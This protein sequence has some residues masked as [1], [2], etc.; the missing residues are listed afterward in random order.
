[1]KRLRIPKNLR[2]DKLISRFPTDKIQ[3]FHRD[4]VYAIL[5]FLRSQM[6]HLNRHGYYP[7]CK[8][9][10]FVPLSSDVLNTVV[11]KSYKQLLE[12]MQLAGIIVIDRH[13]IIGKKCRYYRL[14]DHYLG[15]SPKWVTVTSESILRKKVDPKWHLAPTS[16]E[17]LHSW[18]E[19]SKLQ[20]DAVAATKVVE[21]LAQ[22]RIAKYRGANISD[23][24]KRAGLTKSMTLDLITEIQKPKDRYDQ[25]LFGYRL[26]T[27]L[28]R[29][30]K[31]LRG[32][33]TCEGEEIVQLDIRNSQLFFS[34]WL[35][36]SKNWA[37]SN[38]NHRELKQLF[39]NSTFTIGNS[40]SIN[41]S[42]TIMVVKSLE[43][44]YGQGLQHHPYCKDVCSGTLYE[45]VVEHL[46]KAGFFPTHWKFKQKRRK[47]KKTLLAQLFANPND[48]EH[49]AST[50]S[51]DKRP[52]IES[53]QEIY[54]EIYELFQMIKLTDYRELCRLLQRVESTAVLG[55]VCKAI[56]K[57]LP[58]TPI[59]TVHDSIA[60]T[61][62]NIDA[63]KQVAFDAIADFIGFEP[64]LKEEPWSEF[65]NAL[66]KRLR[67]AA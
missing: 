52:I 43:I 51:D 33:I 18:L 50:Y 39:H 62:S 15:S 65:S 12:W 13:Y 29:I 45:K 54:P 47:V 46:D 27:P 8:K 31:E 4:K 38:T 23:V 21:H 56:R 63:V 61:R 19:P 5:H 32:F 24:K 7:G 25:D 41:T 49:Q 30:K 55:K 58:G 20:I 66:P 34:L 57:E 64:A 10:Y 9:L 17:Y 26:H 48:V 40:K 59:Y 28:T 11:G 53:F 3:G 44:R 22:K 35:L 16:V 6:R 37:V 36:N 1:M 42:Y 67:P 14:D 2:I 60:T